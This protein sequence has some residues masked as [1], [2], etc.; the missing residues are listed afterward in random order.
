MLP[1]LSNIVQVDSPCLPPPFNAP[2]DPDKNSQKVGGQDAVFW[3]VRDEQ[4]VVEPQLYPDNE[5]MQEDIDDKLDD[6][7][8]LEA[9]K[10]I[11]KSGVAPTPM[12]VNVALY[13]WTDLF[14]VNL[15]AE[16]IVATRGYNWTS[17]SDTFVWSRP[18]RIVIVVPK[19]KPVWIDPVSHSHSLSCDE[20]PEGRHQ[21]VVLPP[22][23]YR[24]AST[25][26]AY[27][28]TG[29]STKDSTRRLWKSAV[30]TL[31][32][33]PKNKGIPLP[34]RFEV[35]NGTL[36]YKL[37]YKDPI[38]AFKAYEYARHGNSKYMFMRPVISISDQIVELDFSR[39]ENMDT[40]LVLV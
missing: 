21:D 12:P 5:F 13:H 14:P 40:V 1:N 32:L 20:D 17:T 18:M 30:Q 24:V 27:D 39:L 15:K 35:Q 7:N 36:H 28:L 9:W 22:A 6:T 25:E 31:L 2:R 4:L 3:T 26:E 19:G 8:A 29:V 37:H 23:T 34:T 10:N 16:D 33:S 11:E 38:E